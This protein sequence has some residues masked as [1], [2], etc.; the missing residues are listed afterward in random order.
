MNKDELLKIVLEARKASKK[1]NF[2]QSFDLI[3]NIKDLDIKKTENQVE[4]FV[5]LNQPIGKKKS[6]CAL[7]GP[8]MQ[9]DAEASCDK[10]ILQEN[11]AAFQKDKRQAKKLARAYD[12]FIAQANIMPQVAAAFGRALGPK[13]KMPN[14]KAGCIVAP[15]TPLAPLVERLQRTVKISAKASVIIQC[16]VGNES[17]KDEQVADNV[18]TIHE[19]LVRHLPG[20]EKNLKSMILKL[21]MGKPVRVM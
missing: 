3:I 8:E 12:F 21:T 19:Q 5:T 10:F 6:V 4:F 1:R 18:L 14:P 11:F 20:E 17:M 7:I 15:K 9:A 13:G 2:P 16:M